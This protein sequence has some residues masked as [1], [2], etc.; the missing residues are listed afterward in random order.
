[1]ITID[2]C[3]V[4]SDPALA[5]LWQLATTHCPLFNG[6]GVE[7]SAVVPAEV[8]K[9]QAK[10]ARLETLLEA[11]EF[12]A[13]QTED[14]SEQ[15][16]Q[17]AE[18]N[19]VARAQMTEVILGTLTQTLEA[20][21][22]TA[23]EA[24]AQH[25]RIIEEAAQ[26]HVTNA[27]LEAKLEAAEAKLE[28]VQTLARLQHE[29][30]QLKLQLAAKHSG[31]GESYTGAYPVPKTSAACT[32]AACKSGTCTTTAC[33]ASQPQILPPPPTRLTAVTCEQPRQYALHVRLYQQTADNSTKLLASPVILTTAGKQFSFISGGVIQAGG[34]QGEL[35]LGT[36]VQG[37]LGQCSGD[38]VE[39]NLTVQHR[40][41]TA[42]NEQAAQVI[43][44][45][46]GQI[47][48]AIPVNKPVRCSLGQQNGNQTWLELQIEAVTAPEVAEQR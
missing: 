5:H 31:H 24:L 17:M 18:Q 21:A 43:A 26:V 10:V 7:K 39:L 22:K 25:R 20:R 6:H 46:G 29:C 37:S 4:A 47:V 23:E 45:H 27:T 2:R 30:D 28:L 36:E 16:L 11:Q 19:F 40:V 41:Q 38:A 48:G 14:F 33:N 44:R 42:G 9:L 8:A 3:E 1:M 13:R 34:Q 12:L 32:A 35:P 15:M